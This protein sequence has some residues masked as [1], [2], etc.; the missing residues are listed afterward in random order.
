MRYKI[1]AK[2]AED[3]QQVREVAASATRIFVT[4]ERRLTLST[5]D[6]SES[7]QRRLRRLGAQVQPEIRFDAELAT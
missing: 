4:S 1:K 7:V 2:T 6:L 5:G 3:F